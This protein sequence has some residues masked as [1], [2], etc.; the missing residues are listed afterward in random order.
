MIASLQDRLGKINDHVTAQ[1]LFQSWLA[2]LEANDL[3]ADLAARVVV[4]HEATKQLERRFLKWWTEKR[5]VKLEA[6][7]HEVVVEG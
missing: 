1:A 6:R 5:I 7:L 2:P 3:A 4:E